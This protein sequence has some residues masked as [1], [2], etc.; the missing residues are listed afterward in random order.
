MGEFEFEDTGSAIF[1]KIAMDLT[2]LSQI[3]VGSTA[4]AYSDDIPL[5]TRVER[6]HVRL[7]LKEK[8]RLGEQ[9]LKMLNAAGTAYNATPPATLFVFDDYKTKALVESFKRAKVV[10]QNQTQWDQLVQNAFACD[11][12]WT[13]SAKKYVDLYE[14][15]KRRTVKEVD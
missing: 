8:V 3:K 10:Y 1:A 15:T 7:S 12:S 4:E 5:E 11:Y 9:W 6:Q 13:A 14:S 2:K